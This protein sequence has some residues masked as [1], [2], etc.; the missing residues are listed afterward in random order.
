[1]DAFKW[2]AYRLRLTPVT[3]LP[4]DIRPRL[5]DHLPAAATSNRL[6]LSFVLVLGSGDLLVFGFIHGVGHF[7]SI[8]TVRASRKDQP[9]AA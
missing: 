2:L 8:L 9:A 5:I 1:M 4:P 6:A 7:A 3:H